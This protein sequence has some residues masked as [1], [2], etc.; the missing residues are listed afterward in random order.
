[1]QNKVKDLNH[2]ISLDPPDM[3]KLQLKLGGSVSVQVLKKKCL[4][5]LQS[6]KNHPESGAYDGGRV[7]TLAVMNSIEFWVVF[8]FFLHLLGSVDELK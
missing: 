3:K 6:P 1:M 2:V 4:L 8:F 7:I 5:L